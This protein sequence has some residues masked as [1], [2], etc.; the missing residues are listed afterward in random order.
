MGPPGAKIEHVSKIATTGSVR[1]PRTVPGFGRARRA[2]AVPDLPRRNVELAD[3]M[4]P[5]ARVELTW[6]RAVARLMHLRRSAW[7]D[8]RSTSWGA[9]PTVISR[10]ARA[11]TSHGVSTESS[12][13]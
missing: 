6:A 13:V 2:Q 8:T 7:R 9:S 10:W 3:P 11:M 1:H 5:E 4:C 12:Q